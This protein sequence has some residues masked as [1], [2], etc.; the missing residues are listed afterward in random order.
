MTFSFFTEEDN[1]SLFIWSGSASMLSLPRKEKVSVFEDSLDVDPNALVS[2][3][4]SRSLHYIA[5]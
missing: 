5:V 2:A 3:G 1:L 4:F